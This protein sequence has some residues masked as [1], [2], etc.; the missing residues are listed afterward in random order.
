MSCVA[1]A[2]SL[3][4]RYGDVQL[5]HHD[6]LPQ[7]LYAPCLFEHFGKHTWSGYK[8]CWWNP[9]PI[10]AWHDQDKTSC[11]TRVA[12]CTTLKKQSGLC[13]TMGLLF[14]IPGMRLDL[15][16]GMQNLLCLRTVL[17]CKML[18]LDSPNQCGHTLSLYRQTTG[19]TVISTN[20]W[21]ASKTR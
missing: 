6:G 20:N 5:Y 2:Q 10:E 9:A 3:W 19:T 14:S 4:L 15:F 21:A 11:F 12:P 8:T 17:K 18:L 16:L 7:R 1:I 13:K